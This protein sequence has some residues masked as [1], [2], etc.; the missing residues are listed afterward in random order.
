MFGCSSC[1][2]CRLPTTWKTK[3]SATLECLAAFEELVSLPHSLSLCNDQQSTT[4]TV[5]VFFLSISLEQKCEWFW[6]RNGFA[7][8]PCQQTLLDATCLA[9]FV[10]TKGAALN[11][12]L[13]SMLVGAYCMLPSYSNLLLKMLNSNLFMSHAQSNLTLLAK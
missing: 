2:S 6:C 1:N 12:S 5:D 3:D 11:I 8:P 10:T 9:D 7:H 4:W 13:R